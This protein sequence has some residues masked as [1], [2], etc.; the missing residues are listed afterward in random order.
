M[1]PSFT[2]DIP[3][4]PPSLLTKYPIHSP[5]TCPLRYPKEVPR[6]NI[7]IPLPRPN[8]PQH[9]LTPPLDPVLIPLTRPR[10]LDPFRTEVKLEPG[11]GSRERVRVRG[12][13]LLARE[14]V[15]AVVGVDG[16]EGA[17]EAH[18]FFFVFRFLI[19]FFVRVIEE[20]EGGGG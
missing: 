5:Y 15:D 4:P 20:G 14:G 7:P 13:A 12:C 8:K 11:Q 1:Y 6:S 16:G 3:I 18:V 17:A 2:Q 19:F 10:H 9:H